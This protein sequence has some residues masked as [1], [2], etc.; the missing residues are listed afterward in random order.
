VTFVLF[1]DLLTKGQGG[2]PSPQ[3]YNLGIGKVGKG[4][5][6]RDKGCGKW[7]EL[8]DLPTLHTKASL[9]SL[10]ELNSDNHGSS[11]I[12]CSQSKLG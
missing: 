6:G 1:G 9:A 4:G 10:Q 7:V 8:A 2:F 12:N 3:Q 5:R 11:A